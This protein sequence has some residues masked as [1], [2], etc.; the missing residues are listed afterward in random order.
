MGSWSHASK[1]V[2][3]NFGMIGLNPRMKTAIRVVLAIAL[4]VGF[5]SCSKPLPADKANYAGD[6][7]S[8]DMRLVITAGGR[9]DYTRRASGGSKSV[10]APIQKF[11]GNDFVAG[12]GPVNTRF[13]VARPPTLI[14]GTW[15][16]TVDGVELT[17]VP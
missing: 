5:A 16:M 3:G 9:V 8:A 10:Q 7:R 4:I 2:L 17:K 13:V 14:N 1:Q 6:W 12:L 11:E 15:T